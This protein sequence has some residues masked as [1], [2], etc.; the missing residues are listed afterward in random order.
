MAF[1][2]NPF[3]LSGTMDTS[4]YAVVYTKHGNPG[5]PY[6]ADSTCPAVGVDQATIQAARAAWLLQVTQWYESESLAR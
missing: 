1:V 5:M 3:D 4:A 6:S 2:P